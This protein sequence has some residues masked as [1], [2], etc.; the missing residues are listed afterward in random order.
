MLNTTTTFT[1]ICRNKYGDKYIKSTFQTAS[2]VIFRIK[3]DIEGI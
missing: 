3:Y 1:S 2:A